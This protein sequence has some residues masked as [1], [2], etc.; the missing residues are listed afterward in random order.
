MTKIE[1]VWKLNEELGEDRARMV[2][3]EQDREKLASW[4]MWFAT[5]LLGRRSSYKES[6]QKDTPNYL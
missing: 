4:E 3:E 2:Q 6:V 1:R 5:Q